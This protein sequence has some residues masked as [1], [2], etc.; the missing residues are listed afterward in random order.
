M[1]TVKKNLNKVHKQFP[2]G[3][4]EFPLR[5]CVGFFLYFILRISLIRLDPYHGSAMEHSNLN[6]LK[7]ATLKNIVID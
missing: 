4:I 2:I 7:F 6:S 5:I 1:T 3:F